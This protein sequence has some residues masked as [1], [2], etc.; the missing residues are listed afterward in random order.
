MEEAPSH[1][2]EGQ[3]QGG[4]NSRFLPECR[5]SELCLFTCGLVFE[6]AEFALPAI[7]HSIAR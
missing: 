1:C 4:Q 7:F 5:V 2:F 6:I 3:Q